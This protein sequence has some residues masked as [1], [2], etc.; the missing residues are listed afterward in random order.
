MIVSVAGFFA[1]SPACLGENVVLP[2]LTGKTFST[3]KE[4]RQLNE[5]LDPLVYL[6]PFVFIL[7][8]AEY[9]RPENV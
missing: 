8:P 7:F 9:G 2:F 3:T 1:F 4:K 5:H 6:V